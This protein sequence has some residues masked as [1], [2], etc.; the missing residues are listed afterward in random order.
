MA[1]RI[2]RRTRIVAV[3]SS[4]ALLGAGIPLALAA[5]ASADSGERQGQCNKGHARYDFDVERDDGRFELNFEVDSNTRGQKWRMKLFHEGN[6][7]FRD[8]RTTDREGEVDVERMRP[9]TAGKDT[10]RARAKN[11]RNGNVCQI[12]VVRR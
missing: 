4:T 9:N 5:P 6:R 3:A 8:V 12:R 2:T 7:F 11:L 10:F 1:T